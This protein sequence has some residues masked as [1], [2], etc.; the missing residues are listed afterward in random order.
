MFFRRL[1][2][3]KIF[4]FEQVLSSLF[5]IHLELQKLYL[6]RDGTYKQ[7]WEFLNYSDRVDEKLTF[8][9][10]LQTSC[11]I[12]MLSHVCVEIYTMMVH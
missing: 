11:Y 7:S 3:L 2:E 1:T 8:W 4:F 10:E 12:Y 6:K 5:P 9:S